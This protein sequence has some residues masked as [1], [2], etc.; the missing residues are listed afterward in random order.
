MIYSCF[1]S[2]LT[3]I[4]VWLIY[5]LYYCIIIQCS[6]Y[7][8]TWLPFLINRLDWIGLN[9][10]S[11]QAVLTCPPLA[12]T[13]DTRSRSSSSLVNNLVQ[14][15]LFKTASGIDEPPIQLIYTMDLSLVDTTLHDSPDLVIHKIET[16]AVWRP[17]VGRNEVWRFLT[18]QFT[19]CTCAV[20]PS[21]RQ[22][23]L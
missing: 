15:R 18:R 16:W 5:V 4:I 17:Q 23:A 20:C 8:A 22:W 11:S 1:V 19:C 14:N 6:S 12:W 13:H 10:I 21:Y 3:Y 7:L 2:Y 9:I